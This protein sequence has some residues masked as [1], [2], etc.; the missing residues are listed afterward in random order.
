MDTPIEPLK[1]TIRISPKDVYGNTLYYPVCDKAK[2]F[3]KLT[4][5]KTLT[6]EHLRIIR[7]LGFTHEFEPIKM[8]V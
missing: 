6:P 4:Q 1:N 7:A 5:T 2:A 8:E 3:A